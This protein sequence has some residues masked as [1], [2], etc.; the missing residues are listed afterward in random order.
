MATDFEEPISD[1]EKVQIVS[2]F[3]LHA[4]PG[5]FNEVFND[6][7]LLLNN[8]SILKE[9][10]FGA[11]AQYNKDQLTPVR[12]D[13]SKYTVLVTEYNDLGNSCFLDPR[14]Q[15]SFKYD[16]LKKEPTQFQPHETEQI[17]ESW[18][19]VLEDAWTRYTEDHYRH[20]NCS[21][22]GHEQDGNIS[23]TACIEDHNFQPKNYWNGRWRSV[24]TVTFP[25]VPGTVE[26]RGLVK[27]QV[28]YYE[29]GNVQLVTSK[30]IKESLSVSH[31]HLSSWYDVTWNCYHHHCI[32]PSSLSS[33]FNEL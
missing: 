19:S 30:E 5:E 28:H 9:Q 7:R 22:F 6:V 31:L 23:L 32:P 3:L 13:G 11:F 29:D 27:V 15:Q 8:D 10:A 14:S 26:L 12:I 2:D 18:R 16:H 17:A 4:P 24:W 25:P 1:Q 20:G 21:V 33:C